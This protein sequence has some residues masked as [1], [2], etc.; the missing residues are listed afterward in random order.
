M[1]FFTLLTQVSSRF[2]H[3]DARTGQSAQSQL[4]LTYRKNEEKKKVFVQILL[5]RMRSC[6]PIDTIFETQL[7]GTQLLRTMC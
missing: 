2:D 6:Q 4:T 3:S 1:E 5:Q 7:D